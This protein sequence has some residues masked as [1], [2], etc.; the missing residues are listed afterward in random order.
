MPY[1]YD[2]PRPAITVDVVLLNKT[3]TEVH[4]LLIQ[5]KNAPFKDAWAFP[6][7]F[8]DMN[9]TLKEA[10]MRELQEET[11]ITEINL[12]QFKTYDAI[13]RDPRH[14]TLST[15]FVAIT[16]NIN[17]IPKAAD[18]AQDVKWWPISQMPLLAF[19]HQQILDEILKSKN[20]TL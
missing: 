9:E 10:A 16:D 8:L 4:C 12:Q 20:S 3:S 6:G 2:Y 7:G 18:D 13:D 14:R 17:Q 1:T 15:V 11:G 5:R 19:D